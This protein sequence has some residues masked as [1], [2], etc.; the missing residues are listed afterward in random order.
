MLCNLEAYTSV[1]KL[2]YR[3]G[4]T[5]KSICIGSMDGQVATLAC[6]WVRWLYRDDFVH[7][8]RRSLTMLRLV[9]AVN[10]IEFGSGQ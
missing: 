10:N 7:F 8:F 5:M 1:E 9:H 2:M 3:H 4:Q 6:A